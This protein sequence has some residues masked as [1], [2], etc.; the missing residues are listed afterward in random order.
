[1]ITLVALH[2]FTYQHRAYRTGEMFTAEPVT[3]AILKRQQHVRFATEQ[4]QPKKPRTYRRR[5]L[6]AETPIASDSDV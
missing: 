1:V 4:D 6:V 5:D 3:A 2:S